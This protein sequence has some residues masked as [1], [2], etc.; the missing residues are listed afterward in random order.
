MI[1]ET[2]RLMCISVADFLRTTLGKT[3]PTLFA[4]REQAVL[5]AM[6]KELS[7]TPTSM[8]LHN[9]HGILA[10]VYRLDQG[11][12]I[13]AQSITKSCVIPLLAELVTS[14]GDHN[15]LVAQN[16]IDALRKVDKVLNGSDRGDLGAFLKNYMLGLIS[17][18]NDMLQ[19]VQGKKSVDA[20][21]KI[22]KSLGVLMTQIGAATASIAPQIMATFQTMVGFPELCE[23][24]LYSWH[25]FITMLNAEE[26]APHVGSTS[27]AFVTSW[28]AF[29]LPARSLAKK[30]L[31]YI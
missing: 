18:I 6:D 19:D 24:T 1:S 20:K 25:Q 31:K 10:H 2:C 7:Q 4:N 14:L 29:T 13:D 22:L 30:T 26:L 3:L 16:A 5:D 8:F 9:S 23:E 11:T 15:E 27:A 17:H 21:K 28:S 12:H